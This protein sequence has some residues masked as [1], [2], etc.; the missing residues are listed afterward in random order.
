MNN[1]KNKIKKIIEENLNYEGGV[2]FFYIDGTVE[3]FPRGVSCGGFEGSQFFPYMEKTDEFEYIDKFDMY[4]YTD[5]AINAGIVGD[6]ALEW[7][8]HSNF[9]GDYDEDENHTEYCICERCFERYLIQYDFP[10]KVGEII[11]NRNMSTE[12]IDIYGYPHFENEIDDYIY[13]IL[14]KIQ[15]GVSV[16]I[17]LSNKLK[18][19]FDE[20]C[21]LP[22]R[23]D[24][25]D[26]YNF[27]VEQSKNSAIQFLDLPE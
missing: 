9:K 17:Y 19:Y 24:D 10:E 23:D 25:D 6:I 11:L 15:I 5:F 2:L 14:R 22:S 8:R 12:T 27:F 4:R 20:I 26:D 16:Q 21:D 18:Y 3:F 1:Y 7:S 13:A